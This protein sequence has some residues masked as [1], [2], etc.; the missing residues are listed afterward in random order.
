L[1]QFEIGKYLKQ[2]DRTYTHPAYKVDF[3]VIYT[4]E[5]HREHKIIIEYDGFREHFKEIDEVNE[6]NYEH[7]YS[8][9]DVYRQKVLESY[10]YKFLR[11]NKFNVG[12]S[13]I[14]TLDD[15]INQLLK[16][17]EN[18]NSLLTNIHE[19]IEGLQNGEMKECLKCKEVKPLSDF[20][21]SSLITGFGR[22]CR[23]CK[24]GR[25]RQ[26]DSASVIEGARVITNQSCPRCGSRM[27]FRNGRFGK[28]YGCS[29]YPYCRGT[30]QVLAG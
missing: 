23:G 1:P 29:R 16:R 3:L 28:F 11:I 5:Q 20:R 2:L 9:E 14:A 21:D 17:S 25:G 22:F 13:P 4:D 18:V 30:R 27:A 26:V 24:A 15:R 12:R 6:F 10:G 8:D 19:T 7:Y